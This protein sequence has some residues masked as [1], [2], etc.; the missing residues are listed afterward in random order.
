MMDKKTRS[1]AMGAGLR[2]RVSASRERELM[3]LEW[4]AI[5][6]T[7]KKAGGQ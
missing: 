5:V 7:S 4:I 6:A 3:D 1:G 2:V